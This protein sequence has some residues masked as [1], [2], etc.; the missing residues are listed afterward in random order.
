MERPADAATFISGDAAA[1]VNFSR[2]STGS[3]VEY[4]GN[5]CALVGDEMPLLIHKVEAQGERCLCDSGSEPTL[6]LCLFIFVG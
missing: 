2:V 3:S 1:D 4:G 5:S 6:E